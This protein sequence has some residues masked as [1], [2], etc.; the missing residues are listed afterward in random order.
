MAKFN[1]GSIIASGDVLLAL[2]ALPLPGRC[3]RGL[4]QPPN[5]SIRSATF[6]VVNNLFLRR[7]KKTYSCEGGYAGAPAAVW[8][9]GPRV[10][11]PTLTRKPGAA[12]CSVWARSALFWAPWA[13]LTSPKE[14]G[15][16]GARL[17]RLCGPALREPS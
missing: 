10:S 13:F 5:Y 14:R 9:W 1:K 3:L 16:R 6:P 12:L 8:G 11:L 2:P 4:T 17:P 15:D 7:G